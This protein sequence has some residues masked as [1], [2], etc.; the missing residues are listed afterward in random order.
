[1]HPPW[2]RGKCYACRALRAC[3]QRAR[4]GVEK[5]PRLPCPAR[6]QRIETEPP[7]HPLWCRESATPARPCDIG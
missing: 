6:L 4:R 3:P 2:C 1:M 7:A 5:V